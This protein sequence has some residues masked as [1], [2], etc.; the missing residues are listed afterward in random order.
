MDN[1]KSELEKKLYNF[2]DT[3]KKAQ[4][5]EGKKSYV[6]KLKKLDEEIEKIN[7]G[8]DA[9]MYDKFY[10]IIEYTYLEHWKK[11]DILKEFNID[12]SIYN[13]HKDRLLQNLI[14]LMKL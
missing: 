8:L 2:K 9:I 3:L 6:S 4:K 5:M 11:E 12:Y 10:F 1:K 14:R 13:I 7:N